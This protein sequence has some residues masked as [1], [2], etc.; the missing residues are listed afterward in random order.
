MPPPDFRRNKNLGFTKE[1]VINIDVS[2]IN[3]K[4]L[5]VLKQEIMK[6]PR[7]VDLSNTTS[8]PERVDAFSSS[9]YRM[10][11][12]PAEDP[13]QLRWMFSDA[14]FVDTYRMRMS[15]GTFFDDQ[16]V[17]GVQAEVINQ[18]MKAALTN[19]VDNLRYE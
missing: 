18:A 6:S 9:T 12:A 5:E 3:G 19:P 4:R 1:Q 15:E 8:I 10:N 17:P 7:V 13:Q 2:D 11:N 16:H 14:R